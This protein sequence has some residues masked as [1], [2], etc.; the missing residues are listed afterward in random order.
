MENLIKSLLKGSAPGCIITQN[1][2][3]Y[4]L[5]HNENNVAEFLLSYNCN[6]QVFAQKLS[7][8]IQT[9]ELSS[10]LLVPT[11]TSGYSSNLPPAALL[12]SL[13][14]TLK[15]AKEIDKT[16][17]SFPTLLYCLITA[18]SE[19]PDGDTDL[20]ICLQRSNFD[21]NAF[22]TDYQNSKPKSMI[23]T[24]CTNLNELAEK[25]KID[26]VIG[27]EDDILRTIEVLAK[28][29]K[30]NVV[31]L[32]KAGVGKTAVAEGL[33]LAIVQKKIPDAL[34]NAQVYSLEVASIVAGTSFRGQF[35]EKMQKLLA[36]FKA[37][38]DSGKM[39]ILFIDEIHTIVGSGS[40]NG[41]ALDIANIIKPALSRGHLRCVGATTENEWHQF[42]NKDKALKR[43]FDQVVIN[44]PSKEETLL[45][46]EG[47]KKYYEEKHGVTYSSEAL[48][49]VVDLSVEFITDNALPDKAL[50]L[51]DYA[52]SVFKLKGVKVISPVE[53]EKSLSR[54][55]N[56]SLDSMSK[57]RDSTYKP[58]A[59]IIKESLF[60]Q[61]HAVDAVVKV[62]EKS[63][64]G[65]QSD[66]K[67][68]GSFLFVGPTGVGKTELA[69]L[70]AETTDAKLVRLDMSE[71][72]ESHSVSKLIGSPAGYVG[73]EDAGVLQRFLGR[74]SGKVVLLLD[75]VEKAHPKV[76]DIFLQALD[77]ASVTDSAG[78]AISFNQTLLLFTSNQ[79]AR[80]AT[81]KKMGF[82][83]GEAGIIDPKHVA[84]FFTPEFRNR[85]S[86]VVYFNPLKKDQMTSIVK[87]FVKEL[88]EK[89]LQPKGIKLVLDSS[90]EQFIV[91]SSYDP[92]MGGRPIMR[93][94][95]SEITDVLTT[96]I[97]HGEIKA[98]KKNVKISV[99][100]NSLTFKYS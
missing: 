14:E 76:L 91:D 100:N 35:E 88:C 9:K 51:M 34:K 10:S 93:K 18:A 46:L 92:L 70:I 57:N 17:I 3:I 44:E 38:E 66:N 5:L 83:S 56:I 53:A 98:G 26:P 71:Y 79:G 52:G 82:N 60:G 7:H 48:K 84:E 80:A 69:K 19:N 28:R 39:P 94:I 40:A 27:R 32:G 50:D 86:G 99:K 37:L 67:P 65:M 59:P 47:A 77:N 2:I 43:R 90:A 13:R 55:K 41:S 62:V 54:M 95:D 16:R 15:R 85:L 96:S 61:D 68:V 58:I 73:Y 31:L 78:E 12:P 87:K 45:I 49:R 81:V 97:L 21:L 1:Q 11:S 75:E 24:L 64:A 23:K 30:N 22:L 33:A 8:L 4:F 20:T 63:L 25:G 72:Q 89:K 74:A 29:K 36:E 42:I 6:V